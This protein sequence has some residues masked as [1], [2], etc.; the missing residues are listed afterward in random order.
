MCPKL[1]DD[2]INCSVPELER[3]QNK[4]GAGGTSIWH[5]QALDCVRRMN[6]GYFLLRGIEKVG[7]EMSLSVLAYN[8]KRVINIL[9][10]KELIKAVA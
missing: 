8:M 1:V 6:Q 10:V 5:H 4:K 2:C 3:S 7:A 9:G